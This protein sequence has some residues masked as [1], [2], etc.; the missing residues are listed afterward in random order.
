[1]IGRFW[2]APEL[3]SLHRLP[4]HSVPHDDRVPL[5]GV[6]RF[7]LL[8]RADASPDGEW[9]DI[10]V[11]GCWTMQDTG[12]LP[13]YTNVQMPFDTQ[14]PCVP[15]DN[16]T[17]IYERSFE[18]PDAWGDRRIVVHIGAAESVLVVEVNGAFVG[19]SKDSHLAAEFDVT[20]VVRPGENTVHLRV[21]KWSDASF[22]EDQD[23][24][25]HGGVTRPV[26]LYTTSATYLRDVRLD[27]RLSDDLATGT[28]H[29]TIDVAFANAPEPGWTVEVDA[30]GLF[31]EV[32][33]VPAGG[34]ALGSLSAD[35]WM[36]LRETQ[37]RPPR[38]LDGVEESL[39]LALRIVRAE[40]GRVHFDITAANVEPWSHEHPSLYDV[41]VVLRSPDG[42][43]VERAHHR[44]GFRRVEV[45]GREL[46]INGQPVLIHGVNRHD[47]NQHTGRV[48]STGDMRADLLQMKEFNFNAVRT[49]HYP[50]DP[51]FLD[52]CDELGLYVVDEADIESHAFHRTLCNDPRYLSA[53]VDRV[54]RMVVRDKNHPCVIAWSL[55]NESGYGTNHDAAAGWVRNYDPNRPLH[56]EAAIADDW[57]ATPERSGGG[58]GASPATDILCPMYAPI[59]AIVAYANSGRQDRPLILCEYSHAMGNSNGTLADYWDAIES[60]DGLQGG[61]IWEWW[62]HGLVQHTED[63][64]ERW[65]YGGMFGDEPNDR[66][67]CCDGLVWPDRTPKPAM[68]EHKQ[69]A[70]QVRVTRA[71]DGALSLENGRWFSDLSGVSATYEIADDESVLASGS[72]EL[73]PVRPRSTMPLA[74]PEVGFA[75]GRERWL[76]I[77]FMSN[78]HDLAWSQHQLGERLPVVPLLIHADPSLDD[79]GW[80][81]DERFASA[82]RLCLWRAPTDNDRIGGMSHR[83]RERGLD[84]LERKLV[85]IDDASVTSEYVTRSGHVITHRVRYSG[86]K[87]G[88]LVVVEEADVPVQ[89]RD[90]PRIG[91]VLELR[92]GVEDVEWFGRGPHETYPDRKL[93][94]IGRWTSTV[95]D[96]HVDY[97][98]PSENGGRA[99]V[100]W[101]RVGDARFDFDE[102]RQVSVSHF[103]A[104]DLAGAKHHTELVPRAETIVHID[105]AHRGLGTAS[106]GPDTLKRYRLGPGTYRWSWILS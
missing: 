78:G 21:V 62:D 25:W 64:G 77:T 85:S 1:M 6:W 82:P 97:I 48:V 42:E 96:M 49:S 38:G 98:R 70:A 19:L 2:E 50:N 39:A 26:F 69:L 79:D 93:A 60:T 63:G 55:G 30:P 80:L 53:F 72:L 41:A 52:L 84:S 99:D 101:L 65:A 104:D 68:W 7:Q 71:D 103:R 75:P 74:A 61:F 57:D 106:C 56:Y 94:R 27:A 66:N 51:A 24:W 10:D 73:P 32:S 22:I 92:P 4:M 67:F 20:S 90:L 47:F 95:A 105:A 100:R 86:T 45:V 15:E 9:R 81:T 14:P 40:T 102:P 44:I 54:S 46:L 76:T 89:I 17:G 43:V 37:A 87:D 31:D 58:K 12:D 5:D 16:P 91:T 34:E 59:G 13:Q 18:L 28:L 8:R 35:D 36:A 23:H 33:D 83:W 11:P 88:G 3:T 29:A